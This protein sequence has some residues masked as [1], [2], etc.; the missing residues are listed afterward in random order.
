VRAVG[1]GED[2]DLLGLAAGGLGGLL[3]IIEGQTPIKMYKISVKDD[4]P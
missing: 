4:A 1:G 3:G 2:D